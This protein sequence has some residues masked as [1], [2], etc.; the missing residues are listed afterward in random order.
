[1]TTEQG[2]LYLI[3]IG[4]A[5]DTYKIGRT[6]QQ[7]KERLR[8]Y[9]KNSKIIA[10]EEVPDYK[11][12]ED[13]LKV[14]FRVHCNKTKKGQEYFNGSQE[15]VEKA[16]N[17]FIKSIRTDT[18]IFEEKEDISIIHLEFKKACERGKLDTAKWLYKN[19]SIDILWNDNE[20][21][22]STCNFGKYW[23]AEWLYSLDEQV[24]KNKGDMEELFIS[25][26]GYGH[27]N[28]IRWMIKYLNVETPVLCDAYAMACQNS[29]IDALMILYSLATGLTDLWF[30]NQG[31]L[32]LGPYKKTSAENYTNDVIKWLLL[33]E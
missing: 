28:M 26:C 22:K 23:I 21:F 8:C 13:K 6:K 19:N 11:I 31:Y 29:R 3:K 12:N 4:D 17:E 5:D 30:L 9:P 27:V 7:A 33:T 2:N 32:Y 16:F 14:F 15:Q 18:T 20:I 24:F 25:V 10:F 1:M